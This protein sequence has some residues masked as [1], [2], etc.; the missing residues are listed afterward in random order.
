MKKK[1][2]FPKKK[3]TFADLSYDLPAYSVVRNNIKILKIGDYIFQI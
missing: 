2:K 3:Y 1:I